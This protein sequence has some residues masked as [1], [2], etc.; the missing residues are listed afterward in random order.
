VSPSLA[1]DVRQIAQDSD[2]LFI[3]SGQTPTELMTALEI[4]GIAKLFPAHVGGP[5][6]LRS[7]L[8]VAPGAKIVPTG[9]IPLGQIA[10]WLDAGA[11]AVGVG[12]DLTA[13]GDIEARIRDLDLP[14]V[15]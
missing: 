12:R 11:Y 13:S 10:E 2:M 3:E 9:G 14:V 6:Y 7:F 5:A 8:S 15:H 4:G 1:P